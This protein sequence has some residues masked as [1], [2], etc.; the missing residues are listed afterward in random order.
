[1]ESSI[2]ASTKPTLDPRDDNLN[3]RST[4]DGYNFTNDG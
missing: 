3:L 2:D 4:K 1:M